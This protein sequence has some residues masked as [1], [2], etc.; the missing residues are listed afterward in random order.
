MRHRS[1]LEQRRQEPSRR[2]A[3]SRHTRARLARRARARREG[4]GEGV[5]R[6]EEE[7]AR[8][9]LGVREAVEA[10]G[11]RRVRVSERRERREEAVAAAAAE[12]RN[13]QTDEDRFGG[14]W[15]RHPTPTGPADQPRTLSF[16]CCWRAFVRA[17]RT[18]RFPPRSSRSRC[19]AACD[20]SERARCW[21]PLSLARCLFVCRRRG[22]VEPPPS[23]S[24]WR[25]SDRAH[26]Y[27]RASCDDV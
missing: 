23:I 12:E 22:L 16:S 20:A 14:R 5:E 19:V 3:E 24:R 15:S 21:L 18:P 6:E 10:V 13:A 8:A 1:S 4:E 25:Q 11:K 2:T 9:A 27:V 7:G 26:R 17:R